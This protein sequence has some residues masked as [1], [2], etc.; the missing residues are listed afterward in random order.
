MKKHAKKSSMKKYSKSGS[1]SGTNPVYSASKMK[2]GYKSKM[3]V[4]AKGGRRGG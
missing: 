1:S 3:G 4:K 2:G